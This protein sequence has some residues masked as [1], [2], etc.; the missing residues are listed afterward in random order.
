MSIN[1][2]QK[3]FHWRF[4]PLSVVDKDG[5]FYTTSIDDVDGIVKLYPKSRN[6]IYP[7][8][9]GEGLIGKHI[10]FEPLEVI[11]NKA[12]DKTLLHDF[13]TKSYKEKKLGEWLSQK[14][15]IEEKMKSSEAALRQ[16]QLSL[17]NNNGVLISKS[18]ELQLQQEYI[19]ELTS[20]SDELKNKIKK[21]NGTKSPRE[22]KA[23]LAEVP[24]WEKQLKE[25]EQELLLLSERVSII[26][27]T[28]DKLQE[29]T[30]ELSAEGES[31]QKDLEGLTQIYDTLNLKIL[32]LQK[33]FNEL[34]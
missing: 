30:N 9:F 34:S 27:G 7:N 25:K 14:A 23:L 4:G 13:Y 12:F 8:K 10:F 11:Q 2:P 26:K 24:T 22:T 28:I 33:T 20:L 17:E 29:N 5:S 1:P 31:L 18:Q 21:V 15:E 16:L 6:A 19:K 32:N 3:L